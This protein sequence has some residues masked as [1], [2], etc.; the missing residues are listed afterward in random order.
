MRVPLSWLREYVDLDLD[1]E[2][3]AER[4]TLLG[5][6]VRGIER[7][8]QDWRRVVV[9]E[10]LEVTDHPASDHLH[11]T[12]VRVG[13]AEPVLSIVCG[14]QNIAAGQRVPVALPGAL[15]PGDRPINVSVIA[16]RESEG[17]LC[18]GDELGLTTDA[19]GILI[20]PA[21][22]P[23]GTPLA[24]LFGDVVLDVDVKPNRGDALSLLGLARE[25]SAA[26]G[27]PVR[28]PEIRV[29]ESGSPTSAH[30]GVEVEDA[31]LCPRFVGRYLDGVTVGPSPLL[32]Q[33][34]LSA[35]GM[36]PVSNVVDASNYV[37]LELGKPTHTFDADAL[38]DGRIIVRLARPG[39]RLE[40]LDHVVRDLT[41]DT[42]VIAD[43]RGPVGIA[44]VMGGASS[45][46]SESTGRIVVESAVFDPVSIRRTAHRYALRSEAS[47]R[48][49][50][51]QETRLA[52]IGADRVAQLVM[53]WAGAPARAAVGRVDTNPVEP[54]PARLPFRPGRVTR[55]L[56]TAV[57]VDEMR[58][59]LARVEVATEAARPG[60][61]V[62]VAAG[63]AGVPLDGDAA[64]DALVAIV[65]THRRDLE[66]EADVAEEVARVR[67]YER[68][69]PHLPET[70]MPAYRADPRRTVD[71]VRDLLSGRGL[72][73]VV[74][75]ALISPADHE[76]LAI[77]ANDPATI[78]AAN[79]IASDH[80]Q[81]RRSLLP[82]LV[83][84]LVEN[85][86]QR[87]GDVAIFE[88]GGVHRLDAGTPSE[89]VML[90]I[91]LA[92]DIAGVAW[93]QPAHPADLWD[94]RGLVDAT[95]ARLGV[96]A[97]EASA[98]TAIASHEH[99]GRAAVLTVR[100]PDGGTVE[101]GRVF[102]IHPRYLDAVGARADR[103]AAALLSV[104]AMQRAVPASAGY[105]PFP[106][107]PAVER[108]LAVVVDER[109]NAGEVAAIIRESAA[110]L[111]RDL[112]LFDVYR[113][114][115]LAPR[116]RSLAFRLTLQAAGRTLTEAE[117]DA[118]VA[119][120]VARRGERLEARIRT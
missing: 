4:L 90:G 89:D 34:R 104:A 5:M 57:S 40:T 95:C 82:G 108:D 60:D 116:E 76:R 12:R 74:T 117:I 39:E 118:A 84:V 14:A 37:M 38:A 50:K 101:L 78:R 106:R 33:A 107:V 1:P 55:L 7:R 59:L 8:G 54:P 93:N 49:E 31:W 73:E 2:R 64:V 110:P 24:D 26:T 87:R 35:A 120:I 69:P 98:P 109:R 92:G 99:P 20:L 85:E 47:L 94:V 67:G 83:R 42:L 97:P 23:L 22:S 48:F 18:S 41:P 56:G 9:G 114:A 28:W 53:A 75:H 79:P 19:D 77:P 52:R 3:L 119:T 111:L 80:S 66:I 112:R 27:A 72:A 105:T 25:V 58:K 71:L 13:D 30:L 62:P 103:A 45:E 113:G 15:L 44:G 46:V 16:G 29:V 32:V 115:P 61:V 91:L 88:I 17:M 68:I 43:P 21:E 96:A 81:L 102:E 10:L 11:L 63:A 100:L 86:R 51:G 65:P 36:R 70:L 6:E